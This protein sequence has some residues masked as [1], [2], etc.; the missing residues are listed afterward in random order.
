MMN[1]DSIA[2][3][4]DLTGPNNYDLDGSCWAE[5][6]EVEPNQQS[7]STSPKA[8]SSFGFQENPEWIKRK[9]DKRLATSLNLSKIWDDHREFRKKFKF[10][11]TSFPI[12]N[13]PTILC[14]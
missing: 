4:I 3:L 2:P 13:V 6:V 5:P 12:G 7:S 1:P 9:E 11:E 8:T 14:R 10:Q